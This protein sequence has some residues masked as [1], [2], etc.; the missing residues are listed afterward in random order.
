VLLLSLQLAL[1]LSI[2]KP[3][4]LHLA[5][6]IDSNALAVDLSILEARDLDSLFW[7]DSNHSAIKSSVWKYFSLAVA[8]VVLVV[9]P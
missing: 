4:H 8:V 9:L 1:T 2:V 6:R 3:E 5:C 7:H